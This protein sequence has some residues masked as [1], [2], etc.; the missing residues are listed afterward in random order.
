MATQAEAQ[1]APP[2]TTDQRR[3]QWVSE[4]IFEKITGISRQTLTNWRYKDRKQ[5]R[6]T[7]PP[8]F[9]EYRLFGRTVRYW[10]GEELAGRTV[11]E[12][13]AERLKEERLSLESA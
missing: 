11:I 9:P 10:V 8:G 13:I 12:E 4:R 7:A 2:R 5:K 6:A 3:G 1:V